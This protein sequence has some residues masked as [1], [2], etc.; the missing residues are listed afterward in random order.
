MKV[1]IISDTHDNIT[2]TKKAIAKLKELK[3]EALIHCG[4]LASGFMVNILDEIGVPIYFTFGNAE[5]VVTQ[6]LRKAE[7][8]QIIFNDYLGE[9]ELGGKKIAFTHYPEFGEALA[10]TKKYDLV[11]HGHTHLKKEKI[12]EGA[13]VVNPGE[14]T[15]VKTDGSFA[16]YDTETNKVEFFDLK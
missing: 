5:G 10:C 2:N 13:L 12:I 16:V 9:I 7:G 8:T 4:D 14:I 1:G 3:V 11:C 6:I 15:T